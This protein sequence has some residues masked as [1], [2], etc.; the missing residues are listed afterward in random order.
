VFVKRREREEARRL[1][2][3]DGLAIKAIARRLGVSCSS[4]SVWT[5][6]IELSEA[7]HA[8]LAAANPI[9]NRQLAGHRARADKARDR[10]L[11]AQRHGRGRAQGSD[12]LHLAG[13]MLYWAEGSRSRNFVELT[14][15]DP[16]MLRHFLRFLE[17]CY[18]VLLAKVRLTVNCHLGNGL[19]VGEIEDWWL[20]E[21]ALPRVCLRRSTV[22]RVSSQSKRKRNTL[23]YGTAST[24]LH[25]TFISQSIHGAIQEYGGFSRPEWIDMVVTPH[26]V[27]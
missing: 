16:A 14:N 8:T 5:R 2:R 11:A 13:C 6:D 25:S 15:S 27:R 26:G 3:D 1:R 10:R 21:L 19:S 12:P 7:Q 17:G 4:V 9:Y 24:R 23:L 20:R 22:D 18:G